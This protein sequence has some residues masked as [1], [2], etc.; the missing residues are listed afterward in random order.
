MAQHYLAYINMTKKTSEGAFREYLDERG[1]ALQ[2]LCEA[3]GPVGSAVPFSTPDAAL[4]T[5]LTSCTDMERTSP[6]LI[7]SL[8]LSTAPVCALPGCVFLLTQLHRVLKPHGHVLIGFFEGE[9]GKPFDHAVTRAYYW[10][11]N[12]MT[13]LFQDAGF[14]VLESETR[15][16]PGS[17]PHAAIAAVSGQRC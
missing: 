15:H 4:G 5:G 12:S 17:R 6:A 7:S 16:D 3:L 2:R 14:D 10:S 8:S 9:S 1:P 11:L 13:M